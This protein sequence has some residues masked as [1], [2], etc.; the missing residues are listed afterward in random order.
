MI[1]LKPCPFCPDGGHPV[2]RTEFMSDGYRYTAVACSKCGV[3]MPG[4]YHESGDQAAW[5][6]NTRFERTCNRLDFCKCSECGK[7]TIEAIDNY[8][9]NCGAKVVER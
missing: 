8:C 3:I 2:L 1:D 9:S 5:D 4:N 6:W 7:L